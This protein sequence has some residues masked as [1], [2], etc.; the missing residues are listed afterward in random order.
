MHWY[1]DVLKNKYAEFKGRA[2]RQEYWMFVLINMLIS[3]ALGMVMGILGVSEDIADTI[4]GLYSLAVLIPGLAVASRRLHDGGKSAWWL[5]LILVPIL[6]WIAL[7]IFLCQDSQPGANQYGPNP[8]GVSSETPTPS[9]TPMP[10]TPVVEKAPEVP[11]P[12]QDEVVINDIP[13]KG[14][15]PTPPQ[16]NT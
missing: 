4:S 1:T 10:A 6:G 15:T 7:I 2:A 16:D 9:A 11:T 12:V 5:L 3:L 13:L 8:K 14:E